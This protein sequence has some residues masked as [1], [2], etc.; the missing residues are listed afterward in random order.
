MKYIKTFEYR[1]RK[2][3]RIEILRDDKYIIVAP[4][5]EE[6]SCKYGAFTHWCTSN[7]H[8][9]AW[10][11]CEGWVNIPKHNKIVYIIQRD[12]K[13]SE[14]NKEQS[15]EYY[16]L[17]YKIENSDFDENDQER[18]YEINN[19]INSLNFSKIAVEYMY[20]RGVWSLW[21]AN[22]ILISDDPWYYNLDDLPIDKY[23]I[24]EIKKFC[25][26]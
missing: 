10:C 9:G 16:Y 11:N 15:E 26:K 21:C 18:F 8:S 24:T 13:M 2:E 14:E 1:A 3:E 7:P 19:D 23:A 20:S 22:N 17:K 4:L 5:T 6:A 25:K 12:Y